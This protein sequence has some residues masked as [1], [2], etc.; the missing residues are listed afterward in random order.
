MKSKKIFTI[1]LFVLGVALLGFNCRQA[2]EPNSYS[3]KVNVPEL[4]DG[5]TVY[6]YAGQVLSDPIDSTVVS[7]QSIEFKGE[8]D[9]P[10]LYSIWIHLYD[11]TNKEQRLQNPVITLFINNGDIAVTANLENLPTLANRGIVVLRDEA[12]GS[13]VF[14]HKKYVAFLD[15]I[16]PYNAKRGQAVNAYR[17]ALRQEDK[18]PRAQQ[19][20][21]LLMVEQAEVDR[22][23]YIH[24]F[25]LDN[26]DNPLGKYLFAQHVREFP[27]E[28]IDSV[29]ASMSPE[30][31]SSDAGQRL[32]EEVMTNA[33]GGSKGAEF[34]DFCL[35][36]P[37]GNDIM[38][39][40]YLGK[41]KYVLLEFWASWCGPCIAG[42]PHLKKVYELYR[43]EGFEILGV[44]LDD[45]HENWLA[46]LQRLDLPWKNALA[47]AG[48]NS[49][50]ARYYNVTG[51][52]ACMLFGPEGTLINRNA[53][54]M[55]LEMLMIKI[56]GDKF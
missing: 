32:L 54:D 20:E 29:I 26:I 41:G 5:S 33:R 11:D 13:G 10:Q 38:L 34:K 35:A 21:L 39:S 56:F 37:E 42:F 22:T 23:D 40:D 15:G 52:P 31:K 36:D 27:V 2:V 7:N 12:E 9:Y 50:I 17:Q 8:L 1:C 4:I 3:I 14:F 43:S 45:K 53:R 25:I 28:D 47:A 46:A 16:M 6:L 48:W 55:T 18:M 49:E 30:F 19:I 24:S 51:V 44:S